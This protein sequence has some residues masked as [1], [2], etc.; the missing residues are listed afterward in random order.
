MS[1]LVGLEKTYLLRMRFGVTSASF[2]LEQPVEIVGGEDHLTPEA[3]RAAIESLPGT[4]SQMPPIFSAIKQKGRPVYLRARLG[5]EVTM[6]A[7]DILVHEA[8]VVSIALPEVTFRVRVS[9][10]TYIR[11]LVR[12]LAESLGTA[13]LL[14]DLVREGIGHW[15]YEDALTLTEA[16]SLLSL[17]GAD[18]SVA[19]PEDPS[20]PQFSLRSNRSAQDDP[21]RTWITD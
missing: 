20:T 13:G 6:T 1:Q 8:E 15:R 7:R 18:L 4:H 19:T 12:D 3:V 21:V 5:K 9:K 16:V 14:V 11:S 10:G 17:P 2:D